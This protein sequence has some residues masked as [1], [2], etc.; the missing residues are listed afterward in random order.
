MYVCTYVCVYVYVSRCTFL[1]SRAY[2]LIVIVLERDVDN[3]FDKIEKKVCL[4]L[5]AKN[6]H[7]SSMHRFCTA[8]RV[9]PRMLFSA[10]AVVG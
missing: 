7:L 2:I 5:I 8:I 10:R 9:H 1:K 4:H 3:A 6:V